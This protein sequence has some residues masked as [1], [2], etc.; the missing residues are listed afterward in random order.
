MFPAWCP[1]DL[2]LWATSLY[3][4]IFYFSHS[5]QFLP[6]KTILN[7]IFEAIRMLI[8]KG[9]HGKTINVY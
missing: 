2:I 5:D 4:F 9:I 7:S 1:I 8:S 3:V 6:K